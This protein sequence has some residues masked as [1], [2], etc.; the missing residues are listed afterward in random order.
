M[1]IPSVNVEL[2]RATVAE[3][4]ALDLR[5]ATPGEIF[6]LLNRALE[7]YQILSPS[8]QPGFL[9]HRARTGLPGKPRFVQQL[10]YPPAQLVKAG[11]AHRAGVPLFY[12][13]STR[14]AALIEVRPKVGEYL[15]NRDL[16]EYTRPRHQSRRLLHRRV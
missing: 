16:A 3:I 8:I 5:K 12:C 6:A 15:C 14:E 10:S 13:A 2:V 1:S 7:G 9:F 4:R 11:R